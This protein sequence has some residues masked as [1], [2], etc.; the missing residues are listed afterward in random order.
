MGVFFTPLKL[1]DAFSIYNKKYRITS[2][3]FVYPT[4]NEIRHI[5]NLAQVLALERVGLMT[6]DGDQTLY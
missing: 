6:F 2:R 5:I 3:K 1:K 4:F